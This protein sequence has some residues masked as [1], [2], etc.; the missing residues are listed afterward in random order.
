MNKYKVLTSLFVFSSIITS[1]C[2]KDNSFSGNEEGN[3]SSI[4]ENKPLTG[5]NNSLVCYFSWSSSRNTERM[6]TYIKEKINS[7][8]FR[9]TPKTPY[10]TNYN[11]V[12]NVAQEEKRNKSRPEIK[13]KIDDEVFNKYNVV[14]LGYPIWWYDAPMIIYSFLESYD[15][16]DKTIVPFATSGGS[17]INEE[18]KFEDITKTTIKNGLTISYYSDSDSDK[19]KIDNW[20][21]DL[22]L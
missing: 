9:I 14:Y 22:N 7:N 3:T 2:K 16:K 4:S 19:S 10:T 11:E 5:E 15:F 18:K 13:D 8:I 21:K 12:L 20:L 1:S 17:S 6:A